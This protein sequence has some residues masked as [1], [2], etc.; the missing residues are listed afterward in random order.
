MRAGLWTTGPGVLVAIARDRGRLL[1]GDYQLWRELRLLHEAVLG[2]SL[3]KDTF[4]RRMEPQLELT[5]EK[6]SGVR[7]P[8]AAMY[9]RPG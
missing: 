3:F 1:P 9:R 4:R 6:S 5:D 8:R 7:G 2:E